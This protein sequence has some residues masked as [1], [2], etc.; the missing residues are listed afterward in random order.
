MA[1]SSENTYEIL[2]FYELKDQR[3]LHSMVLIGQGVQYHNHSWPWRQTHWNLCYM[4]NLRRYNKWPSQGSK[5]WVAGNVWS[6][7]GCTLDTEFRLKLTHKDLRTF[8]WLSA[9]HAYQ[10][11]WRQ[12]HHRAAAGIWHTLC[13]S[14]PQQHPRASAAVHASSSWWGSQQ[15]E[16]PIDE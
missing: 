15:P 1:Q 12:Q 10:S 7:T 9:G 6:R 2:A 14:W 13:C 11:V 3:W 8:A 5:S 4:Y 16:G